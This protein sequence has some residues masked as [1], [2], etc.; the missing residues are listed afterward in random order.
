MD[1]PGEAAGERLDHLEDPF[2]LC[3][4]HTIMNCASLSRRL[5]PAEAIAELKL[6]WLNESCDGRANVGAAAGTP[7]SFCLVMPIACQTD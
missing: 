1:G 7:E 5:E 4:C 2:R 3:R 6:K